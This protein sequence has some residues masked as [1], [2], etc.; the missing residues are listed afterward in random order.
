MLSSVTHI[1]VQHAF[2]MGLGVAGGQVQTSRFVNEL[3]A[4]RP[5]P[6][7]GADLVG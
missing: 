3:G 7:P 1:P 2:Q 6:I 4:T 5:A